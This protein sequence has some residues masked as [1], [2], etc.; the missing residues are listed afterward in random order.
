MSQKI[1]TMIKNAKIYLEDHIIDNGSILMVDGKISSIQ[2]GTITDF[3]ENTEIIEAGN[4][5]AIPGF[6]DSHVHGANGYDVMDATEKA[7][8]VISNS[9]PKEGVTSF[10]ATTITQ[11]V[12][13]IEKALKNVANFN[14]K[15]GQAEIIGIHLEGPF[16]N[17][18][19]AGA[20]PVR[21]VLSPDLSLFKKWN[22]LSKRLIKTVTFAPELDHDGKFIS[23]L[24]QCG[25]NIS[26]GHTAANYGEIKRAAS[27]GVNQLTHLCNAMNGIH[28]RDIGAVG[29]AFLIESLRAEL[30]PDGLHISKE[31]LEIIYKNMG[32][33]R[34]ILITDAMRAKGMEPGEYDI[35]GQKA[36]VQ[37]NR[38][39][40][41]DGTLAGSILN[42]RDGAELML[43]LEGVRLKDIVKMTAENPAKQ[44]NI[45][46]R[47]GSIA[48][49]KDADI[50]I[51]NNRLQ[52]QY[53]FCRGK[54]AYTSEI[55]ERFI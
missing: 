45:F 4:F 20:Q 53:T 12:K 35:G 6:I 51:V 32:S 9:L 48:V 3:P 38:A 41:S 40:L 16:I 26:A 22:Q 42:M 24:R 39:V 54:I 37:N 13:N 15:P 11:S 52:I 36:I 49:G 34:I 27:L 14:N 33:D 1:A 17:K 5:I 46:H 47:K 44:I 21:H 43:Q 7:L 50:V 30:I 55:H 25:I 2:P 23:Y 28:H 10:L 8:D 18:N 31:M 19:R 29:A